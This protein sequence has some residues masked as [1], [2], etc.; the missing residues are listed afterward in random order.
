VLNLSPIIVKLAHAQSEF[1]CAADA[2]PAEDW[3][4]KPS[5]EEWS[6]AE[7]SA[8]LVVVERAIIGTADRILHKPP[9]PV[10]LWKRVHLPLWLVEVRLLRFKTPIPQDPE[11]IG[12]K[13]EMLGEVRLTRERAV[14]FLVE[15]RNRNLRAYRWNHA[16]LGKL[17]LYEWFEMIA[18]H[19][20]RHA[21]QIKEL[22]RRLPKV[23]EISQN[24]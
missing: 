1:L 9:K 7:V 6:A 17:N 16:F 3:T 20:L 2:I 19:Q 22:G 23:V 15:T 24:Q 21:K 8:H 18:A 10:R 13:E 5:A 14:A 12:S 4:R 11:L